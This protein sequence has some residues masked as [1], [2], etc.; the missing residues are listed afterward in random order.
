VEAGVGS[1]GGGNIIQYVVKTLVGLVDWKPETF[2]ARTTAD[3]N[4]RKDAA[5]VLINVN[6]FLDVLK[7]ARLGYGWVIGDSTRGRAGV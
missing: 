6:G 7:F 5:G 2:D 1:P 4:A 3:P